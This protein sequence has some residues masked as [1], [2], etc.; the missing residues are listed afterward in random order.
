MELREEIGIHY[1]GL[2]VEETRNVHSRRAMNY[3]TC[4]YNLCSQSYQLLHPSDC[5]VSMAQ[6]IRQTI[7]SITS[8]AVPIETDSNAS[9]DG[10][11]KEG[12]GD[13]VVRRRD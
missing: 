6:G 8:L 4:W 2:V 12:R 7:H 13:R 1:T 5:A 11:Q 3:L 9:A 10:R